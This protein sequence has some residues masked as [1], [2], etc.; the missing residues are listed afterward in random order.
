M[1]MDY[2]VVVVGAGPA[3][4]MTARRLAELGVEVL[5]IEKR[6][7]IGVPVRCGEATSVRGIRELGIELNKKFI[8][9]ETRGAY[10]YSPNGYAMEL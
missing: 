1:I 5:L 8:A 2:D 7:E 6:P 4:C 9:N 3:G 10:I